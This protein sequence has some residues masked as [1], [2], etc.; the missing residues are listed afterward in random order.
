LIA[1][2]SDEVIVLPATTTFVAST[3]FTAFATALTIER[4]IAGDA[5]LRSTNCGRRKELR[6]GSFQTIQ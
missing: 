2:C 5:G 1:A 4:E 3:A 6:F